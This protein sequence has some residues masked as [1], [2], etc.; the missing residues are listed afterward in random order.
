MPDLRRGDRGGGY[1]HRS[2]IQILTK[3]TK[4]QQE[5]IASCKALQGK[6]VADVVAEFPELKD[7]F[8][9]SSKQT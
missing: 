9:L 7:I 1:S 6:S 3:M 5:K 4:Q 8:F 2:S